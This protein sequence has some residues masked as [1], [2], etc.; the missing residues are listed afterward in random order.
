LT[1]NTCVEYQEPDYYGY[2]WSKTKYQ[3]AQSEFEGD[4]L[5][6]TL[7]QAISG[8]KTGSYLVYF[9]AMGYTQRNIFRA[10][11]FTFETVQVE[12]DIRNLTVGVSTD[13]DLIL[14][15]ATGEVNYRFEDA[16]VALK[17][18]GGAPAES[19]AI[20]TFYNQ[21]GYGSLVKTASSLAP[22]ESYSVSSS[23][24]DTRIKLYAKEILIGVG[25]FLV[26]LSLVL[27]VARIILKRQS[28]RAQGTQGSSF[29]TKNLFLSLGVSF[30]SASLIKD[31]FSPTL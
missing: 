24:A 28:A 13:S 16:G 8:D 31:S 21:I 14:R 27:I 9:R 1:D 11:K 12:D 17:A 18:V 7:P 29:D 2:W 26:I 4:T 6:I 20:D 25:I 19:S 3:K 22:L 23:F 15:G 30:A 10:Y 5:T